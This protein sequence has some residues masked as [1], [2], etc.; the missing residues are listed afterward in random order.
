MANGTPLTRARPHTDPN[1]QQP[2]NAPTDASAA[3]TKRRTTAA[4]KAYGRGKPITTRTVK[5]KKLRR[6]LSQLESQYLDATL[7]AHDAELLLENS[8][9]VLEAEGPL[10]RTYKVRQAD[11]RGSVGVSTAAK[12]FEL[13]LEGEGPYMGEYTANGRGLLLAGRKGHVAG[14]EWR[15]GGLGCEMRLGERVRDVKWLH[16]EQYFAVAQWRYVYIYDGAGV[17]LH[18]LKKHVEVTGME[19]LRHH[20]LL[21]TVVGF[22]SSCGWCVRG[23][24]E[25]AD[26]DDRA[27]RGT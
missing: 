16:N 12:G 5:D 20:F 3:E 10:E 18:C 2:P 24:D 8:A 13:R 25:V 9:G 21:A 23:D 14:V 11:V 7:K 19:F 4:Q 26:W 6:N 17:E 22:F 15:G 1:T 27:M